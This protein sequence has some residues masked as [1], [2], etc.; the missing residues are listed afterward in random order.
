MQFRLN[1]INLVRNLNLSLQSKSGRKQPRKFDLLPIRE[2]YN[3]EESE[4]I[5]INLAKS[6]PTFPPSTV[7]DTI[8]AV[9]SKGLHMI[10][11]QEVATE[12]PEPTK[13]D[14]EQEKLWCI[15]N[16]SEAGEMIACDNDKCALEWFHFQ[17]VNIKRAPRGKW[18]C[19]NCSEGSTKRKLD[20]EETHA[21]DKKRK[22]AQT[23]CPKCG[24]LLAT[25]Y[26]KMHMK[27]FCN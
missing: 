27:K 2:L 6:H 7:D 12:H 5:Q 21:N 25:S 17:C 14:A 8:E 15:C 11:E 18:F 3:N 24:K 10:D 9:I 22:V 23:N 20:F 26:L 16:S 19:P 4:M 1:D 13:T